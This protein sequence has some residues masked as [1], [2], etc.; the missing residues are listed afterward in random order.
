MNIATDMVLND[1]GKQIMLYT[2]VKATLHG[3]HHVEIVQISTLSHR[4][5]IIHLEKIHQSTKLDFNLDHFVLMIISRIMVEHGVFQNG[6]ANMT[7]SIENG[8][9]GMTLKVKDTCFEKLVF[10]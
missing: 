8:S 4:G 7:S 2:K 1:S 6:S 9:I 10:N 5:Y 3:T